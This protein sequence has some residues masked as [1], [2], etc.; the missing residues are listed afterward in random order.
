MSA[1]YGRDPRRQLGEEEKRF[2]Y[3]RADGLC[4]RCGKIL[5]S[6]WHG[7]HLTSHTHGGA[8][9]VSQMEAWC[10]QCNLGLGP[11]DAQNAPVFTPRIWQQQ[12]LPRLLEAIYHSGVATLHAAPGAGKTFEAAWV[13]KA[14]HDAGIVQRM[15]VVVPGKVLVGQWVEELG[16]LQ[17]HLDSAPR[18]GVIELPDTAG[19]VVCYQSLPGTAASHVVRMGKIPTL[20]VWDEVHH[21]A[22]HASW[23]TA[24]RV[25][26]GDAEQDGIEHARA[27]LNITGTLFRSSKRQ[28]IAT[29]GYRAVE[30]GMFEAHS[31][32]S[33]RTADLLGVELRRPDLY[34]Y[35]GKARLIDLRTQEIVLGEIADLDDQQRRAV[36]RESFTSRAWLRGFCEEAIVLLRR[37]QATPVGEREPLKLL[38]IAQNQTAARRAADMLNEITNQDF[39][40]LVIS[41]EPDAIK[42]LKKAKRLRRSCAIVAVQMVTE[43]FDCAHIA[44]TAYASNTTASLFVAQMMARNMRVTDEERKAGRMLP[45]QILI[46]NNPEIRKAFA[47]A[48]ANAVHQVDETGVCRRCGLPLP[49]CQCEPGTGPGPGLPR[50]QLLDLDDPSLRHAVV[51]GHDDGEVDGK[52]LEDQWLPACRDLGIWET[53]APR[54]A[55][56]ARRVR[57]AVRIYAETE[58]E[59]EAQPQAEPATTGGKRTAANPRDVNLSHRARLNKAERWMITHIAH[60]RDYSSPGAL[61]GAANKAGGIG[62]DSKGKGMRDSASPGQLQA[63]AEWV[64]AALAK[65]CDTYGCASPVLEWTNGEDG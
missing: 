63:A 26:V 51:L 41:E 60:D 31:D 38:Y 12:A 36:M 33:I 23:G 49:E 27:V 30:D 61:I 56:A 40:K 19:A 7:A 37:Q 21:L 58:P 32:Y 4:Q 42:V 20:V 18:N 46:P 5:D 43:G 1:P 11:K 8:T 39:A 14:L 25:M 47:S 48:L 54:V 10:W 45:A 55:V 16:K 28:R 44:T 35:E 52:E 17:I 62:Y 59:P 57:P 6:R 29:V 2:L 24:A 13:F 34:T 53:L 3:E 9:Q 64:L 15:I 50:Y 22:E 65:H